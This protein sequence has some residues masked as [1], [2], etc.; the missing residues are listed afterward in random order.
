MRQD[1]GPNQK[2][3]TPSEREISTSAIIA[4][5]NSTNLGTALPVQSR[6]HAFGITAFELPVQ[7]DQ[8]VGNLHHMPS[9]RDLGLSM[10]QELQAQ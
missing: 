8:H 4:S 7:L 6:H 3:V 2:G 10:P 1:S 9:V 5:T